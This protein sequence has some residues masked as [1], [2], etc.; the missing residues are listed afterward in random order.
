[1]NNVLIFSDVHLNDYA[2]FNR[3][4]EARLNQVGILAKLLIDAGKSHGCSRFFLAG[5]LTELPVMKNNVLNA[6]RWFLN[7][8]CNHFNKENYIIYGQH[9][10][11][12]KDIDQD[13]RYSGLTA[14]LPPNLFYVDK[15]QF[16][17]EGRNVAFMNWKPIQD[18]SWIQGVADLFVG[19]V[20]LAPPNANFKGQDID[21][22]KFKLSVTGD[23]HK[24]FNVGKMV[25]IGSCVQNKLGDQ[26][27]STAIVWHPDD[28]SWEVVDIDPNNELLRLRYTSNRTLEGFDSNENYYNVYKPAKF[29]SSDSNVINIPKWS[30]I[31]ELVD[32]VIDDA[33]LSFIHKD[34]IANCKM[35]DDVDFNFVP[36]KLRLENFRSIEHAEIY[37]DNMDKI[38][39]KGDN[40]AGKSSLILGLYN[41][42]K[43]NRS[44]KDFI[45]FGADSCQCEI[46]F[47]YQGVNNKILRGT[48]DWGC[49]VNGER[50]P[51]NNKREFEDDMYKRYS[52]L[53]YTDIFF[54]NADRSTI[55]GSLSPERKSEVISKLFR[56][57]KVDSYNSTAM[58]MA[59]EVRNVVESKFDSLKSLQNMHEYLEGKLSQIQ[60]PA[61]T[62]LDLEIERNNMMDL[63]KRFI[64][65]SE[66]KSTFEKL[67]G[68]I[69]SYQDLLVKAEENLNSMRSSEVLQSEHEVLQS[70]FDEARRKQLKINEIKSALSL[71]RHEV[72]SINQRGSEIYSQL[73]KVKSNVCPTCG[74]KVVLT[75]LAD[76]LSRQ[77]NELLIEKQQKE[78]EIVKLESSLSDTEVNGLDEEISTIQKLLQKNLNEMS[79]L[80]FATDQVTR[81]ESDIVKY[82]EQ[83]RTFSE[84][85]SYEEVKLPDNFYDL[86]NQINADINAHNTYEGLV[87]D[88]SENESN[89]KM[90]ETELEDV[91]KVMN[92]MDRYIRITGSTGEVYKEIMTRISKDF[93][94]DVIRY[95]VN[96]YKFR[97]KDHLDLDVQYNVAGRWVSY[98][99]LSSGQKTMADVN[100]LSR[101][102]VECG[103]LVFDETLKHLSQT[104]T[105]YC[106][107]MMSHMNVHTM[108]LTSHMYGTETFSNKEIALELDNDGLTRVNIR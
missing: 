86:L 3:S 18:L 96:K 28:N 24:H 49:W 1:M 100:F 95:E 81:L 16:M 48:K 69:E 37:F 67:Q 45:R 15:K 53:N 93:S 88:L 14:I 13:P 62:K 30:E 17:I 106:L 75:D 55:I 11:S 85:N 66:S 2:N 99:S 80:K 92:A 71:L 77:M 105:E 32:K 33:G 61:R 25:S 6:A 104:S 31:S 57:D 43:D 4:K 44:L 74:S 98:Q 59:N 82:E 7:T 68:F 47:L 102:L 10:L 56:I 63:Q 65:Y 108:I 107:D 83:L 34:V 54:F 36:I 46:E 78:S 50:L 73:T 39:I 87:K 60:L 12:T 64:A 27:K 22:K 8:M 58:S 52:F 91:K 101:I 29:V 103:L 9:D 89:I 26:E 79:N 42:L 41:A 5:D 51:Y 76:S 21:K 90:M 20:T 72:N 70:K 97:N 19:H 40:G 94:D 84:S 38:S 35:A 23:I